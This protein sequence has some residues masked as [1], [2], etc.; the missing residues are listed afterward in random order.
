MLKILVMG[1]PGA[2][3]THLAERLAKA[4]NAVHF[5]ADRVR[6]TMNADLGF[7][8]QDRVEHARRLGWMCQYVKDSGH[9]AIAD[10]VCP[11]IETRAAFDAD[12]MIWMDT[13]K[14]GR[15]EDTNKLFQ[16]PTRFNLRIEDWNYELDQL[17]TLIP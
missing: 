8:I 6:T 12:F 1:L 4:L 9:Y 5:N 10:F 17:L 7:S 14:R 2:G 13:I 15:F 11:T 3:K 16:P